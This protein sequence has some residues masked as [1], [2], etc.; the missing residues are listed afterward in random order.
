MSCAA[1][2]HQSVEVRRFES[3]ADIANYNLYQ[4]EVEKEIEEMKKWK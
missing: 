3:E 1:Y 4:Q 2:I